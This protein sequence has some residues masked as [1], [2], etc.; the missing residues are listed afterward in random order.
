[1]VPCCL[2]IISCDEHERLTV[3]NQGAK[4]MPGG[5]WGKA[6]VCPVDAVEANQLWKRAKNQPTAGNCLMSLTIS[7]HCQINIC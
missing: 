4:Q 7:V 6:S 1:M 5:G 2:R 3:Q